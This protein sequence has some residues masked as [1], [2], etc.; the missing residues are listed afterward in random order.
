MRVLYIYSHPLDDSFHAALRGVAIERLAQAGHEVDLIDLYADGFDPVLSA[1]GRR[2][3]HDTSRNL[4]G[5]G[6]YARRLTAA[7]GL[8]VQFPVWSFGPPA[9]L[10]GFIDRV[11]APGVAFD[12]VPGT[13]KLVPKTNLRRFWAFT[14]TGSPWWVVKFYM[15]DPVRRILKRGIAAFCSKGLDFRMWALHDMD[16]T[17]DEKRRRFLEKVRVAAAT[18]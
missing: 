18:L 7:E 17:T 10:K 6:D 5:I 8:V 15:G 3:Y 2:H 4:E 9:I 16:D 1:E 13:L 12:Y 11:F 14:T